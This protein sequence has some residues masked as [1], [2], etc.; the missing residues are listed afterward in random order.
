[1]QKIRRAQVI[2]SF[3]I[4]KLIKDA[5]NCAYKELI[6]D[7][8]LKNMN[9]EEMATK[10]KKNI[11]IDENIYVYEEEKILGII[12]FGKAE[13]DENIGEIVCL[14]VKTGETRKGI[15]TQLM[16]F[17]KN[18]LIQEGYNKMIIWCLKGNEQG[19]RFYKKCGGTKIKER[20]YIVK[21]IKV[22]E[23]GFIYDLRR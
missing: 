7:E 20:D 22:R 15:G 10:W 12:K 19:A 9:V 1:M 4:A 14:Y 21:G 2:D 8:F 17:A 6:S 16:E 11:E 18:E 3:E 5:W 23:E 13:T